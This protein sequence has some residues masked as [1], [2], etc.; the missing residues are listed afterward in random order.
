MA[1][2][3]LAISL[4]GVTNFMERKAIFYPSKI[5]AYLQDQTSGRWP[6]WVGAVE[7]LKTERRFITGLGPGSFAHTITKDRKGFIQAHCEPLEVLLNFGLLGL[8]MIVMAYYSMVR[9]VFNDRT[10]VTLAMLASIVTI[11]I[12]SLGT[13]TFQIAPNIFYSCIIIGLIYN[14][15]ANEDLPHL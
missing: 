12:A 4:C 13:F 15:K 9:H 5:T 6:I 8:S 14:E 1:M 3:V 2:L 11:T 7:R 10:P